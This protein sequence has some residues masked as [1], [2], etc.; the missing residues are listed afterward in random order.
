MKEIALFVTAIGYEER[1]ELYKSLEETEIESI[2]FVHLRTDMAPEEI[3]ALF[4]RYEVKAA[5]I[6]SQNYL[7]MDYDI[8]EFRDM[9]YIENCD[10]TIKAEI[11]DWAGLCL[12]VSHHEN[13]RL[14]GNPLFVEVD[15]LLKKYPVGAWHL[16]AIRQ[17]REIDPDDGIYHYD[18][19]FYNDL[20]EFDYC[21][22]YKDFLPRVAIALE[23][24]NTIKEQLAAKEYVGKLLA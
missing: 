3:R 11:D 9:V 22:K 10:H 19:H 24:E 21:V 5:N 23:L 15:G 20:C 4:K 6:H 13:K 7:P 12:D 2:P 16:N 1:Q 17:E 18:H 8:S 14:T